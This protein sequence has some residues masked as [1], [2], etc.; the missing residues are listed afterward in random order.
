[1][2][3]V[4]VVP[5]L[6]KAIPQMVKR[7][8]FFQSPEVQAIPGVKPKAVVPSP[9]FEEEEEDDEEE[10]AP[11]AEPATTTTTTTTAAPPPNVTEPAAEPSAEPA[12]TTTAA[13][14]QAIVQWLEQVD[15][16]GN[17]ELLTAINR[18]GV[19]DPSDF[20]YIAITDVRDLLMLIPAKVNA[21]KFAHLPE[22]KAIID[23]ARP[24]TTTTTAL[25][26]P[27]EPVAEP[28]A[29]EAAPAEAPAA[30]AAADPTAEP[31]VDP[32]EAAADAANGLEPEA[33]A[34]EP[35]ADAAAE[36]AAADAAA[37]PA[38]E[39][40]AA[41]EE[42][43]EPEAAAVAQKG[44]DPCECI[45]D[46]TVIGE[47]EADAKGCHVSTITHQRVCYVADAVGCNQ[48]RLS[49]RYPGRRF[50]PCTSDAHVK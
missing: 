39:E 17:E 41:V 46:K 25:S 30:D 9:I 28:A 5:A 6:L 45:Y 11:A 14:A 49:T 10:A 21:G 26:A 35:A 50:R 7:Q 8:R 2:L 1:M 20:Q 22:I 12:T 24:T 40:A 47:A 32:A 38:A 16:G 44:N 18:L 15:E 34:G 31:V 36:P 42:P 48:G 37:E 4:T 19:R 43:A 33:P 13:P 23:A 29:A 27:I 3:T